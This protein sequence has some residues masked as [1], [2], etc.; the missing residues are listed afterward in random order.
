M[1]RPRIGYARLG[2]ARNMPNHST[3][4]DPQSVITL[5]HTAN[6]PLIGPSSELTDGSEP[7]GHIP[8]RGQ[9]G[10]P[11]QLVACRHGV[12]PGWCRLGGYREG[13]IPGNPTGVIFEAYLMNY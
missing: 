2:L 7:H 11:G 3:I 13:G 9:H 5:G 10:V 4:L 8:Q 12:Y 6:V 1:S